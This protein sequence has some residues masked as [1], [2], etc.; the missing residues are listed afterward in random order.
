[1]DIE[2]FAYKYYDDNCNFLRDYENLINLL[3]SEREEDIVYILERC[4]CHEL[5][6]CTFDCTHGSGFLKNEECKFVKSKKYIENWE[7]IT[8][9]VRDRMRNIFRVQYPQF[10]NET[11]NNYYAVCDIYFKLVVTKF[12]GI[13]KYTQYREICALG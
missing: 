9:Y 4:K 12:Y 2:K 11:I 13:K 8:W 3:L 1:M 6:K 5:C 10:P 7:E